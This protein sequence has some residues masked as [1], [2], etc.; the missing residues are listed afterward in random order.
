MTALDTIQAYVTCPYCE[1]S[2]LN[3]IQ[4][5]EF[6]RS[7]TTVR[8]DCDVRKPIHSLTKDNGFEGIKD[9]DFKSGGYC[10]VCDEEFIV[11]FHVENYILSVTS[12]SKQ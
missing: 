2:H 4:T 12:I 7:F 9:K 5:K 8:E 6:G 3:N 10:R 11:N 1:D